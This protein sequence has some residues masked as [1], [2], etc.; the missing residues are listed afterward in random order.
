MAS[1]KIVGCVPNFSEGC[2]GATVEAIAS[3]IRE[4]EGCKLLDV[5]AGASTNRTVYTFFGP[6]TAVVE[7][8]MNAARVARKLI[9]MMKHSGKRGQDLIWFSH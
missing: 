1:A 4:T 9:D 6:P 3:A 7:G 2:N 5:D 8:A